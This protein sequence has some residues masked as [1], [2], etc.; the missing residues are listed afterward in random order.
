VSRTAYRPRI[1]SPRAAG[2]DP[3]AASA[4]GHQPETLRA[5]LELYGI[6]WEGGSV[7]AATKEKVRLRNAQITDCGY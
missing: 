3:I 7:D 5:F 2:S 1:S 6:L 4:L